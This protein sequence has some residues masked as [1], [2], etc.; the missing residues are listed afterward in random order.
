MEA[1]AAAMG[2][3]ADAPGRRCR[4]WKVRV[5]PKIKFLRL[6]TP[7]RLLVRLRDAYVNVMLKLASSPALA[8]AGGMPAARGFKPAPPLKEYDEK[9]IVEIYKT[10]VAQGRLSAAADQLPGRRLPMNS[11]LT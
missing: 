4:L 1:A 10:L 7:K 9:V 11:L 2:G 8:Y 5:V 6:T 3:A